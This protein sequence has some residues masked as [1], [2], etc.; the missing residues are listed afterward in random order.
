MLGGLARPG[1][2]AATTSQGLVV[3]I[4]MMARIRTPFEARLAGY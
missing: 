4:A 2:A 3:A 1:R